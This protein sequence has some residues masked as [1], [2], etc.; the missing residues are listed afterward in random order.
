M[1][2]EKK[3]KRT[4]FQ[5]KKEKLFKPKR[6]KKKERAN[7]ENDGRFISRAK[8]GISSPIRVHMDPRLWRGSGASFEALDALPSGSAEGPILK[9]HYEGKKRKKETKRQ[10]YLSFDRFGFGHPQT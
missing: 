6:K 10:T 2:T 7:G 5:K 8:I 1:A 4:Y 9:T 3:K